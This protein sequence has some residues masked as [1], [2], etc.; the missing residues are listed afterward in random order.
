M[1]VALKGTIRIWAAKIV[2]K[3][4]KGVRVEVMKNTIR[5]VTVSSVVFIIILKAGMN[6][7]NAFKINATQTNFWTPMDTVEHPVISTP[8]PKM[9]NVFG[10]IVETDFWMRQ[11]TAISVPL[12]NISISQ[13]I[14][15]K[16]IT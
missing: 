5:T 8:I 14:N 15:S 11:V 7:K 4:M 3:E 6:Q 10:M 16:I 9:A 1:I 2:W 12:T 13:V